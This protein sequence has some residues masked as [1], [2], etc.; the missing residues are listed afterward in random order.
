MEVI[1]VILNLIPDTKATIAH[2]D[3]NWGIVVRD[4]DPETVANTGADAT[5]DIL[6][7]Q[8]DAYEVAACEAHVQQPCP[9]LHVHRQRL[10]FF[11]AVIQ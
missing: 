6:L 4:G 3:I 5:D 2:L 7:S 9:K 1:M 8:T 11:P 10:R